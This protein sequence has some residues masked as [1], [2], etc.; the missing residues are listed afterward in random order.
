MRSFLLITLILLLFPA[1]AETWQSYDSNRDNKIEDFELISAINDW[2]ESKI[3][4]RELINV[5]LK[6]LEQQNKKTQYPK[7]VDVGN[8]YGVEK[9]PVKLV[10][11]AYSDLRNGSVPVDYVW[12]IYI[13]CNLVNR[14]ET[15]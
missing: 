1:I 14:L 5:I 15:T 2:L 11:R 3:S 6:W 4:D 13:I 8:Y 7:I 12:E 10:A 9:F